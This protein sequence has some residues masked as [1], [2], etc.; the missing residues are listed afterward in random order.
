MDMSDEECVGRIVGSFRIGAYGESEFFAVLLD[1]SKAR[2][3]A[4]RRLME[5]L[6][7]DL[8]EDVARWAQDPACAEGYEDLPEFARLN[9]YL[10]SRR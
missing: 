4:P 3:I 7:G 2:E 1:A 8:A 5:L 6:P 10:R 9:A